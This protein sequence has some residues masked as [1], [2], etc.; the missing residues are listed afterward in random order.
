[1]QQ[2]QL[3]PDSLGTEAKG[4]PQRPW[5]ILVDT[6]AELSVAPRSFAAEIPL[7]PLQAND[8]KLQT[9]DGKNID[10]FGM[11]T[12]QLVCHGFSFVMQFV[13]AN[14]SQPLL[15][16]GS[17]LRN[18]LSLH[19]DNHLGH[20]LGNNF[21]GKIQLEQ[22]GL[23]IYLSACLVEP[24]LN[25]WM[26]GNQLSHSLLPE[27]K[28]QKK[29][30]SQDE[31]GANS[32][33]PL[34]KPKQHRQLRNKRA[35]GQQQAFTKIAHKQ[36]E[37][38]KQQGQRAVD[39]LR[40]QH[41]RFIDKVRL[42]LLSPEHPK[43]SL[44]EAMAQDLSL[45][46]LVTISLTKRWQLSTARLET[47]LPKQLA[48]IQLQQLGLTQSLV[49]H[50]LFVGHEL[51]I[52]LQEGSL[53]I[54]GEKTEQ[55]CF[56][57]KLSAKIPLTDVT[58]LGDK[59]PLI[60][61]DRSLELNQAEKSISLSL[62][63][64]FIQQLLCRHNL[65]DAKATS[66]PQEELEQE[67]SRSVILDASRTKLYKET[68]GALVWAS[69]SRPDISFWAQNLAKSF[70]KPTENNQR[71]LEKVLLYLKGTRH[72][73][74]SLQPPRKLERANCFELLA[75][76]G[77][78]WPEVGRSI[79]N[80][81]LF[82][83]GVPLATS[84]TTQ[85]TTPKETQLASVRL[86]CRMAFHTK[87]LLRQLRVEK[88][89]SLRVLLGGPLA[90]QLGLSRKARH[91]D[92]FSWFGQFQ[93]SKVG[94]QS[95]LAESLTYKLGTSGLHRLLL[96]L[97][98]HTRAAE[99]LALHTELGFGEVASFES[100]MGSFF[101]GSL[102]QTPA[103]EQ[104][105]ASQPCSDQL[106]D[107]KL[108]GKE[109]VDHLAILELEPS[110]G[111]NTALHNELRKTSFQPESSLTE[112]K[113]E[114]FQGLSLQQD[115][116]KAA[117]S[118]VSL[119]VQNLQ[120]P[121]LNRSTRSSKLYASDG[122]TRALDQL[123]A[124]TSSLRASRK[125]FRASAFSIFSSLILAFVIISL[126]FQSL[127][128]VFRTDSLNCISL[129]FQNRLPIDW[130]DELAELDD[131]TLQNELLPT[132]GDRELVK[133]ELRRT[134]GEEEDDKKAE[135]QNLLV[136][137]ELTNQLAEKSSWVDQL[138]ENLLENDDHNQLDDNK[139]L[140]EKNFQ[141]L[142][143]E[144][145]VALLLE[146]HFAKAASTQL[147]GN[148]AWKKSREASQISFD[149]VGDKELLQEELRRQELGYKD[150]WPAYFRALCPTSFED[151]SFTEETFA[152]TSLG[153]ETFT[154]KSFNKNSFADTSFTEETFTEN[155]FTESSL[156]SS[157][158][159]KSTLTEN[160]F[161]KNSLTKKS[162][163]QTSFSENTFLEDSFSENSLE[164]KTLTE[165]LRTQQL[166][167]LE[168]PLGSFGSFE[169]DG[170]FEESSFTQSSLEESSFAKSSFP[171]GSLREEQL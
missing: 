130:A 20:Y 27:A 58:K 56:L 168:L 75:F 22:L 21:G 144:K 102:T 162:F 92:L 97:K 6:G 119:Q 37:E 169:L 41:L 28:M 121:A 143:Y 128:F 141:S 153:K 159:T 158:L 48:T 134:C 106:L 167:G 125:H 67:A 126:T 10:I 19:L 35:I 154:E 111:A 112:D 155:S 110:G 160:S 54:G 44:D 47:A 88:T 74:I 73:S 77:T 86:A 139:K 3:R 61:Q 7:S 107:E 14:V 63:S 24:G 115:S 36:P 142:I 132:L 137:Q 99:E 76:S 98:M 80:V 64:A 53:M 150:L 18:N 83:M 12:L 33:F 34:A 81:S 26:I 103:M 17:L 46:I 59:N 79:M 43:H 40:M 50:S 78:A 39:K 2:Q 113:L 161:A 68:V 131:M 85:A 70:D 149:K 72:F 123:S 163:D 96:K 101:I 140:E 151:T 91:L 16:L 4:S 15:G 55:E 166:G 156:T 135:L 171:T 109:F 94:P 122:S 71:Q 157:S 1:M 84:T 38:K 145:L 136:D 87:L 66:L 120:P 11:K 82:L 90:S 164:N 116:L 146:W 133:N 93:L 60:F 51:C 124:F 42:D 117:Y 5:R 170:S 49:D 127:S 104:L 30:M 105:C 118:K 114:Q 13:I 100:S 89:L 129:S 8:L 95:N 25:H 45:R 57:C 9:A 65:Q 69:M 147:L 152:N 32:S 23:Q 138:Q 108:S 62:T 29:K 52:I 148:E 165:Q 31:G